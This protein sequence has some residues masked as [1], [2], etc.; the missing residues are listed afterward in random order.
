MFNRREKDPYWIGYFLLCCW[1]SILKVFFLTFCNLVCV[2]R[3]HDAVLNIIAYKAD[4]WN[5][6]KKK[7]KLG[8]QLVFFGIWFVFH[9]QNIYQHVWKTVRT[10]LQCIVGLQSRG[11][12]HEMEKNCGTNQ[13]HIFACFQAFSP[14]LKNKETSKYGSESFPHM[15]T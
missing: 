13:S 3:Y 14:G 12:G 1:A 2:N 8:F 9:T 15:V 11:E 4:L 10:K 7:P 5:L 6:A